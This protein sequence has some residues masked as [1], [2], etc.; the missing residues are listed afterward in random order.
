MLGDMGDRARPVIVG[1]AAG[2]L[3]L[4][5]PG[6]L[7][8]GVVIAAA[9]LAGWLLPREPVIAAALFLAPGIA[10]ATVRVLLDDDGP[11]LG[12]L[13]LSFVLAVLFVA[14]LTHVGAGMALRR[15]SPSGR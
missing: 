3:V 2:L 12:A 5:L 4:V 14:I 15:R 11:P 1:V 8:P 6:G 10:G 7:G 9:L 13:V